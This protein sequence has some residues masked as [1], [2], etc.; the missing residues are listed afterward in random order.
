MEDM[1]ICTLRNG[2]RVGNHSSPHS[3]EF[4]DGTIL[5]ACSHERANRHKLVPLEKLHPDPSGRWTDIDLEYT[6]P[7]RVRDSLVLDSS[8]PEVDVILVALPVLMCVRD[9]DWFDEGNVRRKVRGLRKV[10]RVSMVI[11]CDRFC[12]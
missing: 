7:I 5:D 11:H 3:F 10:D 6:L 2:L 9:Y 1:P 8:N 4:E 12:V